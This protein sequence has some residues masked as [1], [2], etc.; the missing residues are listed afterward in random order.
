MKKFSIVLGCLLAFL[1]LPAI[2]KAQLQ[3]PIIVQPAEWSGM[4]VYPGGARANAP[5]TFGLGIPDAAGIDCP[6]TQDFPL[7]EQAPTRLSLYNGATQ[8]NSQFRCM[9]KWPDG[10]RN[11]CLSTLSYPVSRT[12]SRVARGRPATT[13]ASQ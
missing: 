5:V 4:A 7:H 12:A 2:A 1:A 6:G 9:A 8:L 3:V 11:G 10:K 13:R